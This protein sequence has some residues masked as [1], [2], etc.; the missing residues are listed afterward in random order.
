MPSFT[1]DWDATAPLGS[2]AASE[3][4]DITR[5]FKVDLSDRFANM[6]SGLT[7]GETDE[8]IKYLLMLEQLQAT[9]DALTGSGVLFTKTV[10]GKLELCYK[11]DAENTRQITSGGTLLVEAADGVCM[12][13]GGQTIE[14]LKTF[15]S[16][17]FLPASD[18][19]AANEAVRKGFLTATPT[20]NKGV[21][22]DGSSLIAAVAIPTLFGSWATKSV[23]TAYQAPTDGLFLGYCTVT[24]A[25]NTETSLTAATCA[26]ESGTYTTRQYMGATCARADSASN[27][28]YHS[29]M[30]P[31]AKDLWHK[32]TQSASGVSGINLFWLPVGS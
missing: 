1:R 9:I 8:G 30:L 12:L 24:W 15:D 11:D 21:L 31:V 4:D 28:V 26:T 22:Y 10:S 29:F 18:P 13:T 16:I 3:I 19:T 23:D 17:P 14:G 7:A 6:F 27:V 32:A 25:Y 5:E 20:A 2:R